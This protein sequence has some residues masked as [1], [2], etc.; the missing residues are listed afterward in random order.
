MQTWPSD[1]EIQEGESGCSVM[2]ELGLGGKVHTHCICTNGE[3]HVPL[4]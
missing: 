4:I 3:S 1:E 2:G